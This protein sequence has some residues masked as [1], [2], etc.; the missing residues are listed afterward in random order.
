MSIRVGTQQQIPTCLTSL[1]CPLQRPS[2]T[3]HLAVCRRSSQSSGPFPSR[4]HARRSHP[5]TSWRAPGQGTDGWTLWRWSFPRPA[6][7]CSP[8]WRLR[9]L[10]QVHSPLQWSLCTRCWPGSPWP[11]RASPGYN[12][13]R[14]WG[15]RTTRRWPGRVLLQRPV[16]ALWREL[17]SV[18]LRVQQELLLRLL[19]ELELPPVR[20]RSEATLCIWLSMQS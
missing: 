13:R 5:D 1:F 11:L 9:Q 18:P 19:Q 17:P 14:W 6:G 3:S 15:R 8:L 12:L 2:C 16:Q 7:S 4:R 20:K 10:R